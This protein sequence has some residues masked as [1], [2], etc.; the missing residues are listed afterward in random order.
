V[1]TKIA[2]LYRTVFPEHGAPRISAICEIDSPAHNICAGENSIPF[3]TMVHNVMCQGT[4]SDELGKMK[5]IPAMTAE[6]AV[7]GMKTQKTHIFIVPFAL[8]FV[9]KIEQ[10]LIFLNQCRE[11]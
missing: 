3:F 2:D 8:Y 1:G 5:N 6:T 9:P 10:S 4:Y 11:G 7:E